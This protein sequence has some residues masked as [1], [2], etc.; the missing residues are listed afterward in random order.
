VDVSEEKIWR[1]YVS[2]VRAR[3]ARVPLDAVVGG[4]VA[5]GAARSTHGRRVFRGATQEQA[6]RKRRAYEAGL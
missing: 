4:F 1:L 6:N 5:L 2:Q 3:H